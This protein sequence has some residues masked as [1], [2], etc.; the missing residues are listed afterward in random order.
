MS[1][2]KLNREERKLL[3]GLVAKLIKFIAGLD[4]AEIS[5]I[6][7]IVTSRLNKMDIITVDVDDD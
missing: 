5:L 3:R 2:R 7:R 6:C 4:Q 1:S